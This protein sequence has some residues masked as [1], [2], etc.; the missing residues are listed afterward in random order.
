MSEEKGIKETKEVLVG[1]IELAALLAV[2]FKDGV[3]VQDAIS[4][5]AKIQSNPELQAKLIAAYNG[6]DQVPSEVS[7]L[8]LAEAISIVPEVIEAMKKLFDAVKK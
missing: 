8:S 4:I 7:N 3:Q 6:I 1:F 5:I 2:E